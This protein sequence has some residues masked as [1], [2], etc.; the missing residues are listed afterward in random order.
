MPSVEQLA[1]RARA[2][3]WRDERRSQTATVQAKNGSS[4]P[5]P[6]IK[7]STAYP[8]SN[9]LSSKSKQKPI[10]TAS[11]KNN[12]TMAKFSGGSLAN[13]YAEGA[14]R[15]VAKGRYIKGARAGEP[16]VC[17]WF[18]SGHVDEAKFFDL[19]IKAMFKAYDIV[20]AWNSKC[21]IDKH[22]KVNIP[23]VWTFE[24]Q[25]GSAVSG[26]KVLQEPFILNYEKFNSNNGWADNDT[27]WPRVMQALSH[28]S[29]HVSGGDLL[30][31]DLQGGVYDDT[32]VL[33]DPVIL[34]RDQKYGITDLGSKGISSFF[35]QHECNE[36][37]SKKWRR[38]SNEKRYFHPQASTSMLQGGTDERQYVPTCGPTFQRYR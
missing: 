36:Y 12:A 26:K 18:K 33:T 28:F 31:C 22:I 15:W 1:A 11:R 2:R 13:P 38:P 3:G 10:E 7:T 29:Y 9:Q 5:K 8:K 14:F 27:P 4:A 19:D 21:M 16:C 6:L 24:E 30:L 17:K 32:V 35:S 34:S 37:C 20:K 25:H 23:E